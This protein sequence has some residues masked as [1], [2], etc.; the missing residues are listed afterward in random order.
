MIR[1]GLIGLGFGAAVQ[2][3]AFRAIPGAQVV[4]L[5]GQ[6]VEK[7]RELAAASGIAVGG[8]ADEVLAAKLD[9]V[10]I[11]LP[12]AL[13]AAFA[14]RALARGLAVLAEKPLAETGA[15]AAALAR[16]ARGR[17]TAIDFELA[18]MDCFLELRRRLAGANAAGDASPVRMTWRT[19]SFSHAQ[20]KWSW[21][22]DARQHGGVMNLLGSHV[23]HMVEWLLGPIESLGATF[24]S[25]R[26]RAF[27]PNGEE[28]AEDL[29]KMK[30]L[31]KNRIPVEVELDNASGGEGQRWEIGPLL[32]S[33]TGGGALQLEESGK[34]VARDAMQPGV[35]WRIEPFRRLAAR[36]ID[37]AA[38]GAE[39]APGFAAGARVQELIDLARRSA[40][41]GGRRLSMNEV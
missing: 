5:G 37:C 40:A 17:T 41:E 2:L 6:R 36:F 14:E 29:V 27:T 10:S 34:I 35:D 22:T 3:P 1:V 16:A 15:R 13:G 30:V 12:P 25:E 9:A 8:S 32:L 21:K 28:P 24:S 31:V 20:R 26:T 7:A 23:F 38:R 11:A 39:C 4:A 33:E 18:E 19:R